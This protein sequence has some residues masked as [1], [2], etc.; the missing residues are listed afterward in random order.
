MLKKQNRLSKITYKTNDTFFSSPLFNLRI[1]DNGEE[2]SRFGLVVSKK[3][4]KSAVARNKIKRSLR[5]AIENNLEKI[6]SGKNIIIIAKKEF[7]DA[8]KEVLGEKFI[9]VI[10]KANILK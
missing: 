8:E 10:K 9:E 5:I 1:S 7:V 2:V 6:S 3:I 4:S